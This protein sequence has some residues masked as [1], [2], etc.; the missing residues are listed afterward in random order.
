[1]ISAIY[2][3]EAGSDVSAAL[4]RPNPTVFRGVQLLAKQPDRLCV[5]AGAR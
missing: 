3:S 2:L 4:T 1:M 5:G